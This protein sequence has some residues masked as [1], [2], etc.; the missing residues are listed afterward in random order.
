[1]LFFQIVFV[2]KF[3]KSR[4]IAYDL[5]TKI[6]ICSLLNQ[7]NCGQT[8]CRTIYRVELLLR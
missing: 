6:M 2:I 4:I 7:S 3:T 8:L 1:M 5:L